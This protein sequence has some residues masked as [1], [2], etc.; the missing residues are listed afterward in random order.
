[1]KHL[2][3]FFA[4][5]LYVPTNYK[6]FQRTFWGGQSSQ[7]VELEGEAFRST[8]NQLFASSQTVRARLRAGKYSW[9]TGKFVGQFEIETRNMSANRFWFYDVKRSFA[10]ALRWKHVQSVWS[11]RQ[12][13]PCDAQWCNGSEEV[14][15]RDA[16]G[17]KGNLGTS[18]KLT[19]I[20]DAKGS[21]NPFA[22]LFSIVPASNLR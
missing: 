18:C 17:S 21:S 19:R 6:T 22:H 14:Q 16:K 10:F 3:S 4:I 2:V 9:N 5:V 12:G 8:I 11:W 1:M 20:L 7:V 13:H 15:W